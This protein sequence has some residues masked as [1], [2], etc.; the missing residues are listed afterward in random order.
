MFGFGRKTIEAAAVAATLAG[1]AVGVENN[2]QAAPE[3]VEKYTNPKTV[4]EGAQKSVLNELNGSTFNETSG[5]TLPGKNWSAKVREEPGVGI[6]M[7]ITIDIDGNTDTKRYALTK[8]DKGDEGMHYDFAD[9]MKR[10]LDEVRIFNESQLVVDRAM[11][12]T[13]LAS[14]ETEK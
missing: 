12:K 7:E 6:V 4:L 13:P 5:T 14:N 8:T 3:H 9:K 10:D 2:A 11:G 1:G